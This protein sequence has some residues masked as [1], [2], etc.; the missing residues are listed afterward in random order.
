MAR[1]HAAEERVTYA[2]TSRNNRKVLQAE[3]SVGPL[4]GYMTRPTE[5]TSVSECSAFEYSRVKWVGWCALR[6]LLQFIRCEP[7]L[8][9]A[10]SWGKWIFREPRL[11]ER[12]PL[13]AATSKRLVEINRLRTLVYVR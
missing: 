3:F 5:L 11:S 4:R 12:P 9:D 1:T 10:G 8:L 2:V 13:E 7:L 6:E